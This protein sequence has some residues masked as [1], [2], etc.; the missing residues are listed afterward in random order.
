MRVERTA[1]GMKMYI[2]EEKDVWMLGA[3]KD[4]LTGR[5]QASAIVYSKKEP[6]SVAVGGVK[7]RKAAR[8]AAYGALYVLGFIHKHSK[9]I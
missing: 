7:T 3:W 8:D 9:N 6:L 1:D 2:E 4:S 5:W